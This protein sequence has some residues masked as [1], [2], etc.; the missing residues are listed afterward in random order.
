M[1]A[2]EPLKPELA[3]V[4]AALASLALRPAAVERDRLMFLAGQAAAL[5]AT[6]RR[7]AW[8]WP[9]AT[10]ASLLLALGLGLRGPRP[11]EPV[12]TPDRLAAAVP[13][14]AQTDLNTYAKLRSLILTQGVGALPGPSVSSGHST[15]QPL[16][17]LDRRHFDAWLGG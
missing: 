11:G 15:L 12:S 7:G 5:K 2:E 17:P 8:R 16:R 13:I 9:C 1:S 6:R 14:G 10:A 4:E 3:A